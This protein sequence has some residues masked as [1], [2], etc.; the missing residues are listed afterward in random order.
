MKIS[1]C[2][3][4][5]SHQG[6]QSAID[7]DE[8]PRLPQVSLRAGVEA[9]IRNF[10]CDLRLRLEQWQPAR[11]C[12]FGKVEHG[13]SSGRVGWRAG[14]GLLHRCGQRLRASAEHID[15]LATSG[16]WNISHVHV[17]YNHS[18]QRVPPCSVFA[19]AGFLTSGS[20]TSLHFTAARCLK[21]PPAHPRWG[22]VA[23]TPRAY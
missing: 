3:L 8:Q 4:R 2:N 5:A 14:H 10:P 11:P 1:Y 23:S 18:C 9:R 6:D 12:C 20:S 15:E 21:F 17:Q 19:C 16:R 22:W 13:S 7:T